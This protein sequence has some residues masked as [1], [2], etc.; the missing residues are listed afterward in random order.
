MSGRGIFPVFA[1][2]NHSCVANARFSLEPGAGAGA[3]IRVEAAREIAEGEEITVQY[4]RSVYGTVQYYRL[5]YSVQYGTVQY[6]RLVRLRLN[7]KC[8][9]SDTLCLRIEKCSSR[10]LCCELSVLAHE[11]KSNK[12]KVAPVSW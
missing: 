7:T 8:F 10:V 4:Y 3:G 6:Y 11:Y 12:V 2:C 1:V 9:P 5:V